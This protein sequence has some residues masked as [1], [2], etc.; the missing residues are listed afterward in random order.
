MSWDSEL[1]LVAS[2]NDEIVGMIIGTI[3]NNKATTTELQSTRTI[4]AKALPKL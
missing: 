2:M 4:S 3:D 1:V